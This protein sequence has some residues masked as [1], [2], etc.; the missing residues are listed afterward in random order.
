MVDRLKYDEAF[1][2]SGPDATGKIG[3]IK[4][5]EVLICVLSSR[6]RAYRLLKLL[7]LSKSYTGIHR[8]DAFEMLM[9]A[10]SLQLLNASRLSTN[11]LGHI[12]DLSDLDRDGALDHEEF[13]IVRIHSL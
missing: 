2:R 4:I 9:F 3:G 11:L 6:F 13:A 5:K 1:K 12:W 10:F 8:L 7:I